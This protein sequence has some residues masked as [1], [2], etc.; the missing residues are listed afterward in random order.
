MYPNVLYRRESV[1][2]NALA[3]AGEGSRSEY[4]FAKLEFIPAFKIE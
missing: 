3:R 4:S 1:H 2:L